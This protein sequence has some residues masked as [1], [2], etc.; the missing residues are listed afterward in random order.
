LCQALIGALPFQRSGY[1]SFKKRIKEFFIKAIREAKEH[2]SWIEPNQEYE[3]ACVRFV[4]KLLTF[5][6]EDEFWKDFSAFQKEVAEYAIYNSLSQTLIKMTAPGV[7]DFYQGSELFD[8]NLVD[9]DNRRPVDFEMRA[10]FL[11]N[12]RNKEQ[13]DISGLLTDLLNHK[14]DG[15][16]K[17][18]LTYK[19]LATRKKHIRLFRD[20][21]YMPIRVEGCYKENII[22][23]A[24][25]FQEKTAFV[26]APRFVS[27]ITR[28]DQLPV[29]EKLWKDTRIIIPGSPPFLWLNAITEEKIKSSK[30]MLIGHILNKFPVGLIITE[31]QNQI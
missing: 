20:G 26:V 30:G 27:T 11:E 10:G 21:C 6:S 3:N 25:V 8:F 23:F 18:F 29:G 7:P 22:A 15:R 24:R 2:T 12:I 19:V 1:K 17:M 31:K 4:D 5:S 16:I 9:P 13:Q 14:E 28:P